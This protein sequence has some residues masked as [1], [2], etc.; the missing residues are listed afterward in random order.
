VLPELDDEFAAEASEFSTMAELREDLATRMGAMRVSQSQMALQQNT[1]EAL[2]EIVTAEVPESMVD[3]ELNARLQDM[4]GRLQQQ[5]VD[6]GEYLA[7]TG[8]SPDSLTDG[9]R[10]PAEQA[11][12][13]DLALRAVAAAESLVPTDDELSETLAEMAEQSGQDADELEARLREV[14]QLS[15]LRADL[16]KRNAIKW[17]T[18]HVELVDE[19]DAPIDRALLEPPEADQADLDDDTESADIADEAAETS[20]TAEPDLDEENGSE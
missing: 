6:I 12:K 15:A 18:E 8:Q 10:E 17:L 1:A 2:A 16:A 3:G 13:V 9:M 11:V 4:L 14:G 5:G 19:D 7:S 20:D